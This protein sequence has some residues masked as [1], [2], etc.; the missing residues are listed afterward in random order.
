VTVPRI[1]IPG[2]GEIEVDE[3]DFEAVEECWN[4]YRLADG[5]I[6]RMKLVVAAVYR[7]PGSFDATGNPTY[8]ARSTNVM[9]VEVPD[10]LRREN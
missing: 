3:V 8:A 10:S 7:I 1:N 9:S 6:L 2:S 5:T 4:E